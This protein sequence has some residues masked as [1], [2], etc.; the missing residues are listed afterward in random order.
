MVMGARRRGKQGESGNYSIGAFRF[1]ELVSE[2][3]IHK[4]DQEIGKGDGA[5]N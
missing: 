3:S 5:K 1:R 2:F 4:F